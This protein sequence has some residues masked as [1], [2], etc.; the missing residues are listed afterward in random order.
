MRKRVA[1]IIVDT[2]LEN[3]I[4][5][6]FSVVGGGAMHLNNA[7]EINEDINVY[8]CHHEQ[9][10]AF[11]AEGYAKESGK[12]AAVCV[13]SG[14][15]GVNTLNGIYSAYVDS[16]PM[17]V[18]AGHPR[19]ETTV[20][21]CGLNLRC[22]GVQE[23]DIVTSVKNMTKYSVLVKDP[24]DIKYELSK[25]INIAESG[26]KG[27]VWISVP[28]DVQSAVVESDNLKVYDFPENNYSNEALDVDNL[29]NILNKA[30]R[31][32]I[33]TGHG[34][35]YSNSYVKFIEFIKRVR[36]PVVGGA[37]LPDI[38]PEDY[39]MYYGPSG[40]IGP[41]AGNNIIQNS[42]VILIL[43]NSLSVRQTG[44]NLEGFAP[45]SYKIMVDI[46]SDEMEK[47]GLNIDLKIN[48]DL[49]LFFDLFL[50]NMPGDIIS[51]NDWNSFCRETVCFFDGFDEPK[52]LGENN[53][54]AK[55]FWKAF[56]DKLDENDVIALGNSNCVIGIYQYGIKKM[57]QRVITNV[58]SGSMG[59]DLPEAFGCAV[60][61]KKRVICVTG[62]G[63][64]MMN[65]QELQTISYSKLPIKLVVFSNNGYGAIRQ[66][67]SRYFNGVYT[68]CDPES[69]ISFP[70][71]VD[72]AKTFGFKYLNCHSVNDLN[73]CIDRF[74]DGDDQ[75]IL[76]INQAFIDA[77]LP[78]IEA[79][80]RDD[81]TFEKPKYVDFSPALSSEEQ[82]A[83]EELKEKYGI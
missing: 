25:A 13:T 39:D 45:D 57:G 56:I 80:L 14:P 48:I 73:D 29:Y 21:A 6:C 46:S 11:S 9:A 61:S 69:G 30:K 5:D 81:G 2:L 32:V 67:C 15:G 27:P 42:D 24:L 7:F 64:V 60:A 35:R 31:P 68:G 79:K 16:T 49:N 20:E 40:N 1:D 55:L 47:P 23:F 50:S 76:E 54:P 36:I 62:D 78:R 51:N 38:L 83:F 44:Y 4:N 37:L 65:L 34:I 58:N 77:V 22:R 12:M 82:K 33:L 72:V 52:D 70:S 3:G 75:T 74:L 43:G 10:C 59:Y 8:Y 53:I 26:R 66:T 28:L 17:I 63:S 71:F 19:Y 41:R 18:I